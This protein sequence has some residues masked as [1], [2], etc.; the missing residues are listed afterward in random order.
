M[1]VLMLSACLNP[2]EFNPV[3]PTLFPNEISFTDVTAAVLMLTNRSKT[4]DVTNV[5]ITQSEWT[6]PVENPSAQ[7][8]SISFANKP[9]RLE[10]KAQYLTPSDKNYQVVIDYAFDAWNDKPAG[11]G[12][13]TLMVPLPLAKQ[14]VEYIIFRDKDGV[15][16]VDKETTDPDPGDIGNPA[17]DPS[18]GEGSS[19]AIIPPEYRNK[20]ATFVVVSKTSS[21]IIDSVN[22]KM[23]SGDYTMGKIGVSDKQSIALGQGTWE[24]RL[25]YTRDGYEKS[26]GPLNS[27]I[28]PSNDPQAIQ[29]HYLYFYLNKRGD[30]AISPTWP[31]FPNDVEEEDLLP[32]DSGYGRSLIKIINNS[33]AL[34][35]MVTIHNERDVN[36]FPMSIDYGRFSPPIPVQYKKTGY[37]DVIG[38]PAFPIEAHEDYLVQV[39]LETNEGVAYV[40]RRAY[41]KDQV[42]TIVIEATDIEQNNAQGA[43]FTLRNEVTIATVDI[44]GMVIR[45]INNEYQSSY[46]GAD[47]WSPRG[48]INNGKTAAQTV[49]ST[50]AMPIT[51]N[52]EFKAIITIHGGGISTSKTKDFGDPILYSDKSPNQNTRTIILTDGDIPESIIINTRGAKVTIENNTNAYP[53]Q[54]IGMTV[55]NKAA[56]DESTSYGNNTW[57]SAGGIDSGKKAV[58]MVM[59]SANMPIKEKVKYEA[60]ITINGNGINAIVPKD[61][62]PAEL[63]NKTLRPEQNLRTLTI[64]DTDVPPALRPTTPPPTGTA[65]AKVVL[66]NKVTKWPI[67]ITGMKVWN[68]A[69][70]SENA[71]YGSGTWEPK[72]MVENG[73]TAAQMVLDTPTMPI[74]AGAQFEVY[75][76]LFGNGQSANVMKAFSPAELYSAT[77]DADKNIR[78][79]TITDGNVPP[80]LQ[81]P[82]TGPTDPAGPDIKGP[83]DGS[84]IEIDGI[85]WIKVRTDGD[86]VLLMYKGVINPSVKYD[87]NGRAL[88]YSANP[89]IKDY[90]D[91]WYRNLNSPTLK[92][93][94]WQVKLGQS[95]QKTSPGMGLA[96]V[97]A[98][99]GIAFIPRR[100]DI[101]NLSMSKRA[102]RYRFWNSDIYIHHYVYPYGYVDSVGIVLENGDAGSAT[103][104][105]I[106]IPIYARPCIWVT[107]K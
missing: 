68:S 61:F 69:E 70:M 31:P 20:M 63:Y 25:K 102:N 107:T 84:T 13:K 93:I 14:I 40:E 51:Q 94:A 98:Y 28:V 48:D 6:P 89:S 66:E 105:N 4:V 74:T 62:A 78:T 75:V 32:P 79:I 17:E 103:F 60:L 91:N 64:T 85:E 10:K 23:G 3:I 53:V 26:L 46:F 87:T 97:S 90:V 83:S 57:E 73:E 38:T 33:Y 55:R 95:P 9:K 16:I 8:P 30:Y 106:Y 56:I 24:T 54:I 58:Q 29:E 92:K 22:F 12:T 21:Q 43:R 39:T 81:T 35:E 96:G 47:T 49:M 86:I 36:T 2:I 99:K 37:V 76:T 50:T 72:K 77:L 52:A 82:D 34:A 71:R 27:I 104:P 45:N 59:S 1:S 11:T 101:E 88:E 19:P 80:E 42:V 18:I 15:V 7:P 44:I 65:G 5:T 67:Q 100:A 41:L